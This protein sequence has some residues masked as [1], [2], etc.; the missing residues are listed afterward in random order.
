VFP[1][2]GTVVENIPG[3]S[4]RESHCLVMHRG[5]TEKVIYKKRRD[6]W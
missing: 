4:D 3:G 5:I 1:V 2:N 6:S